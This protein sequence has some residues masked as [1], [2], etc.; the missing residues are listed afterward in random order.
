MKYLFA[1]LMLVCS[2]VVNA[3][4][5]ELTWTADQD[6]DQFIINHVTNGAQQTDIIVPGN[7]R[8]YTVVGA[9]NGVHTF[10]ATAVKDGMTSPKSNDGGVFILQISITVEAVN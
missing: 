4:D 6:A 5:I 1:L 8:N 7:L 10:Y 2:A 3:A 9:E